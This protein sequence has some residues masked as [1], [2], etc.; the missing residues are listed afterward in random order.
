[1]LAVPVLGWLLYTHLTHRLA[2][3]SLPR[4]GTPPT[5]NGFL[6]YLWQFYLPPLPF[7]RHYFGQVPL[8]GVWIKEGWGVF[9]WLDVS[10]P[11]WLYGILAA[12]T[13]AIA[14]G[15]LA[16]LVRL[17]S[18]KALAMLSFLTVALGVMLAGLHWEGYRSYI[19]GQGPLL[20]GRYLL[21]LIGIFGLAVGL[22]VKRLGT[23]RGA[24]ACALLVPALLALQCVALGSIVRS[25]FA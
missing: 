18:R 16:L 2:L 15:T 22:L 6:S 9:G 5:I 11:D 4:S 7:M 1:V 19:S 14:V 3:N 25:Y 21:P 8:Y 13:G 10:M 20:Q 17:R 24:Y 23:P 12:I